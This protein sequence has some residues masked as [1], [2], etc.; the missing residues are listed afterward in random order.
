MRAFLP[1]GLPC[2]TTTLGRHQ[3]ASNDPPKCPKPTR[4]PLRAVSSAPW[5]HKNAGTRKTAL[6]STD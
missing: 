2:P 5:Q 6:E 3:T 1:H 4:G